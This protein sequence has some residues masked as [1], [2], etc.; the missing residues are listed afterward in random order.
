MIVRFFEQNITFLQR[1]PCVLPA[2]QWC[3]EYK[4]EARQSCGAPPS[5]HLFVAGLISMLRRCPCDST[6]NCCN[7]RRCLSCLSG[8]RWS[9]RCYRLHS[10]RDRATR[11]PCAGQRFA[12]R[13]KS[14]KVWLS[15]YSV[16]TFSELFFP[17]SLIIFSSSLIVFTI[18]AEKV[19]YKVCN[20]RYKLCNTY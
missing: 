10:P 5:C 12:V 17:F 8:S 4:S 2:C 15:P 1:S 18:C 13:G 11:F 16:S 7:R 3:F 14:K 6:G 20:K 9:L 19:C